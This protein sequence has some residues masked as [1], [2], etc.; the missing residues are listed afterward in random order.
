[1]FPNYFS[2]IIFALSVF[3]ITNV[4]GFVLVFLFVII[5][6]SVRSYQKFSKI[7]LNAVQSAR[8][9]S[10]LQLEAFKSQLSPHYL[11]N[12]LNTISLLVYKDSELSEKYIRKLSQTYDYIIETNKKNLVKLCDE[13][14]FIKA[15]KYFTELK[16]TFNNENGKLMIKVPLFTLNKS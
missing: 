13:L 5:D 3:V 6:F 9:Q 2:N 7:S 14:E 10:E 11:F 16:P 12:N 8:E 1:M 4:I 15:Y